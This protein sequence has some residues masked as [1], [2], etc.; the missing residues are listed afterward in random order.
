MDFKKVSVIMPVYNSEEYLKKAIQSVLDQK[1]DNIELLL[2]DDGSTDESGAICDRYKT[3]S[4]V[5]VFHKENEG[6]CATRNFGIERAQGEYL[7]F[8]DND[9]ELVPDMLEKNYSLAKKYNADV[10]KFG[11]S[12]EESFENGYVD[13]R[14]NTFK[15]LVVFSGE[16]AARYYVA[17]DRDRYFSYIWN[18]MYKKSWWVSKNL[19]FDTRIKCG[20]EDRILNYTIFREAE[21]QVLSPEIGYCYFQRF[22]HSTFKKFNRNMLYSCLISAEAEHNLYEYLKKSSDFHSDWVKKSTEYIIEFLMLMSR[23]DNDMSQNEFNHYMRQLKKSSAFADIQRE[24]N[25]RQLSATKRGVIKLFVEKRYRALF[26][27]SRI[28]AKFIFLK[29]RMG[30]R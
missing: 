30:I 24:E 10:V 4:R 1:I 28:Y 15:E 12:I 25:C 29:K 14:E 22:S 18:G 3:D 20:F 16:E 17:A 27:L 13:K 19:K 6:I 8:I 23:K 11:C 2:I 21:R 9:D 5:R 26:S 7:V